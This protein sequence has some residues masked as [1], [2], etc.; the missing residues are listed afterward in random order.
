[1]GQRQ[2]PARAGQEMGL[3]AALGALGTHISKGTQSI[4]LPCAA[5]GHGSLCI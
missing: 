2:E 3:A 4:L 1:M 5:A